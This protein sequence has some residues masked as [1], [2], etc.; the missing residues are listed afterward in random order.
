MNKYIS[1]FHASTRELATVVVENPL[2]A[3]V[4]SW[5]YRS[6]GSNNIN[7]TNFE[8]TNCAF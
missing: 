4:H 7:D 6:S 1:L 8:C 5:W 3:N 2:E